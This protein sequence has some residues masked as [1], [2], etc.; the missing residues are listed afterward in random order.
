MFVW[1]MKLQLVVVKSINLSKIIWYV[2]L[3]CECKLIYLFFMEV[4]QNS[5]IRQFL[6]D[7]TVFEM[8]DHVAVGKELFFDTGI[9]NNLLPII[10]I[11]VGSSTIN[12]VL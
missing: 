11:N 10:V 1:K 7:V 8:N 6:L 2:G 3:V 4:V 12:G 9:E 5:S